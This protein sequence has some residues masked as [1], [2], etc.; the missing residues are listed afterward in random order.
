MAIHAG[1]LPRVRQAAPVWQPTLRRS[2]LSQPRGA[3]RRNEDASSRV[4][5]ANA[6]ALDHLNRVASDSDCRIRATSMFVA[7]F[8]SLVTVIGIAL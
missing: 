1:N 8:A 2:P 6:V 7:G 5:H 3:V 4:A